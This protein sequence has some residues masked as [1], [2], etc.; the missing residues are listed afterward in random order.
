MGRPDLAAVKKVRRFGQALPLAGVT[1]PVRAG[2][3]HDTRLT[4][5]TPFLVIRAEAV[6]VQE[7][8]LKV[9]AET[10]GVTLFVYLIAVPT[11]TAVGRSAVG[12]AAP[13]I[14]SMVVTKTVRRGTR[15]FGGTSLPVARRRPRHQGLGTTPRLLLVRKVDVKGTLDTFLLTLNAALAQ[16]RLG[17]TV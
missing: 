5:L 16:P 17:G 2:T 8:D 13:L 12:L 14:A 15:P 1:P 6:E 7:G 9:F 4:V 10:V 3:L 11:Q